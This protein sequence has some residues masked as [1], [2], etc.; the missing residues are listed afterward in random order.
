MRAQTVIL[1]VILCVL[2][3]G[4]EFIAKEGDNVGAGASIVQDGSTIYVTGGYYYEPMC[5]SCPADYYTETTKLT[6]FNPT[7]DGSSYELSEPDQQLAPS[8]TLPRAYH[9]SVVSEGVIYLF[10]GV[11][12]GDN[13]LEAFNIADNTWSVVTPYD[14]GFSWTP[15]GEKPVGRSGHGAIVDG[16]IIFIF[17]GFDVAG[18]A[19]NDL[20]TFDITTS[21]WSSWETGI[22]PQPR[23]Y[24]SFTKVTLDGETYVA[25]FGGEGETRT[26]NDLWLFS[27]NSFFWFP[28]PLGRRPDARSYHSAATVDGHTLV[29]YGGSYYDYE[30]RSYISFDDLHVVDL[31]LPAHNRRW[32][33]RY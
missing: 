21:T 26:Y 2:S 13:T 1:A 23:G 28:V 6:V 33:S 32:S 25:L 29:V 18:N 10:G 3:V 30:T 14:D 5:I 4:S 24:F 7:F 9:T 15:V 19:L 17:G 20:W 31:A 8:F 27:V 22:T 16:N 12:N 11:A